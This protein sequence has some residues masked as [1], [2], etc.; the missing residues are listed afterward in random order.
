LSLRYITNAL[1]CISI[2]I[3]F[4]MTSIAGPYDATFDACPY[5][6][7]KDGYRKS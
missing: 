1:L 3:P 2:S 4:F 5:P 7:T 6:Q